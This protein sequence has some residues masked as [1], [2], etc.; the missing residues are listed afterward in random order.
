MHSFGVIPAAGQSRRMGRPKLLL[1]W[2]ERRVIDAVLAAWRASRVT[3]IVATV[4]KS[5]E[6]LQAACRDHGVDV[7]IPDI[8]PAEMKHSVLLALDHIRRRHAPT[9]DDVWLLAP[10]DLPQLDA[11]TINALLDAHA[12]QQPAI[13]VPVVAER[14]GHP[15]LF[16]WP[17]AERV[18]DL[19]EN[20]GVNALLNQVE[21]REIAVKTSA[22]FDDLD[23]PD[24]YRRLRDRHDRRDR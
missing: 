5:D 3:H 6:A 15:V 11:A 2:G 10:A 4:R 24:D 1:P 9:N 16:P 23:T 8:D 18:G 17:L 20:E 12:A 19:E 22:P 14:R 21:V 13:L 7:V